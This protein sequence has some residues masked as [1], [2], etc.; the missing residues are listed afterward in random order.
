MRKRR[1]TITAIEGIS[2]GADNIT[3]MLMLNNFKNFQSSSHQFGSYISV[4]FLSLQTVLWD[5]SSLR[6]SP[7]VILPCFNIPKV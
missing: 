6:P 5:M 7:K 4:F 2:I 1:G 3:V